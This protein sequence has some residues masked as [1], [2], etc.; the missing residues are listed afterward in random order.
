MIRSIQAL[1]EE[2]LEPPAAETEPPPWLALGALAPGACLWHVLHVKSR[3]EKV[4]C[5]D[6][7]AMGIAHY[8]PLAR[9]TR[10]YGGRKVLAELPLFPGYVFVRVALM[11]R[12]QV[13]MVPGVLRFVGFG[14]PPVA[15]DATEMKRLRTGLEVLK[16]EPHPFLKL[17]QRVRVR[18]G[19]L[20]GAE[21][22]LK[23]HRD[24]Y[25]VVLSMDLIQQAVA[26]EVDMADLEM[27]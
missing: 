17:G 26:V 16:A 21:G 18:Y 7:A 3:Q 4:L 11:Q 12:L 23:S 10:H 13:Q 15:L 14:G 9:Q 1:G 27:V 25:R 22:I 19:P 20:A 8:L 24:G 5:E 6:L 2:M